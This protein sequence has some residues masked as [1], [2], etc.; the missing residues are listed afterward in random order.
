MLVRWNIARSLQSDLQCGTDFWPNCQK[1]TPQHW[2]QV[3]MSICWLDPHTLSPCSPGAFAWEHQNWQVRHWCPVLFTDASRFNLSG[4]DACV[5]VMRRHYQ[6]YNIVQHDRFGGGSAMVWGGIALEG[7]M[8]LHVLNCGNLTGAR[9]RDKILRPIFRSYA[10][11]VGPGF[12]LVHENAR[13][14]V[15]RV[16]QRF[17]EDEDTV[18]QCIQRLPNPPRTVQ[19]PGLWSG[20]ISILGHSVRLSEARPDIVEYA[21]RY[22]EGIPAINVSFNITE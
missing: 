1:P 12:L 22:V 20:R 10:G 16:C 9:Y 21:I 18:D 3:S 17:L 7:R 11:A 13:T 19:E 4:S 15:A 14:H 8:E 5:W 6:A 2:I